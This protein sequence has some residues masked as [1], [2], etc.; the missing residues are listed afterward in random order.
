M[1][2]FYLEAITVALGIFLLVAESFTTGKSKT[3]IGITAAL[4]LTAVLILTTKAGT[5]LEGLD[6]S[7]YALWEHYR[8]DQFT[9]FFKILALAC[10]IFVILMSIDF[11]T[12]LAKFTCEKNTE[13]HVGEYYA[14]P[15]IACAAMMWLVSAKSLAML[16]VSLEL[17]TI[18]IYILVAYMRRNVGSLEAGVKYLIL[19]ALSTGFLVYGIAWIY[20]SF[21]T[22]DL[23]KIRVIACSHDSLSTGTLFGLALII[24]A[25]GF[26]I[27]A[28]PMQFWIPD[29]YQGAPT[30]TTAFLSVGSKTAGFAALLIVL[31]PFMTSPSYGKIV[32]VLSVLAILTMLAG[33]LG[34]I[35]QTNFKKLLAYSSI[36]NAGF[37]LLA[38]AANRPPLN[39]PSSFEIVCIYLAAYL[40]TT[41]AAFFVQA[42]VRVDTGSDQIDAFDGL[43]KRH[44]LFAVCVTI[45]MASLAGVP[46]TCGFLGKFLSISAAVKSGMWVSVSVA[47]ISAS[48]GFYYYFKI[49]RAIWWHGAKQQ[50]KISV[51]LL[52]EFCLAFLTLGILILGFY[53]QPLVNLLR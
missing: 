35:P 48:I 38:L 45:I 3:W 21:G 25:L 14:L 34:A 10:T 13:Q 15:V 32:T 17:F 9:R 24:I 5:N 22:L 7:K 44:P 49:I 18:T 19:G 20:G 4:G 53:Y 26:K 1:P 50:D 41:L 6:S 27:G 39:E 11:R 40:L 16:F 42:L 31:D 23:D 37:I 2:A 47:V 28:A 12:V 30:P 8:F 36:A 29:V 46:L 52:S 51:P 43:A 33:N